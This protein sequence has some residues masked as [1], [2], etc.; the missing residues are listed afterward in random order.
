MTISDAKKLDKCYQ[1][2][3]KIVRK[4][5]PASSGAFSKFLWR[6]LRGK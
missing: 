3:F 5:K 2:N 4:Q 6:M 1:D